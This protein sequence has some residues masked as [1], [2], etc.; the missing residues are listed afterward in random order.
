MASSTG[1]SPMVSPEFRLRPSL[2]DSRVEPLGRA[3]IGVAG[4]QT[5]AFVERSP[6]PARSPSRAQCVAGVQTPAFVERPKQQRYILHL[7][8]VSPEFRLRPSLSVPPERD[9]RG[10]RGGV[11]GVQTPAFV[12]RCGDWSVTTATEVVSPEFRLRPSLSGPGFHVR[13]IRR[14]V[15]PEFRLRPSLSA[16]LPVVLGDGRTVVSPEFRLRPSLSGDEREHRELPGGGVAGVQTPAF[17]ERCSARR[18]PETPAWCRRSS[19]SGLR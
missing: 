2:S 6:S 4:V 17:V 8:R 14:L 18:R 5:P 13:T 1:F 9:T 12:E 16:V 11:A 15:S 3:R 10:R 19:D 7:L